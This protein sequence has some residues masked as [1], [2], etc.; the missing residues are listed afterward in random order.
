MQ[1]LDNGKNT[2]SFPENRPNRFLAFS[3]FLIGLGVFMI[4]A[5]GFYL[6]GSSIF[7]IT[8]DNVSEFLDKPLQLKAFNFITSS[9]P[10]IV[11]CIFIAII[12]RASF[13]KYYHF[14]S[15]N[16]VKWFVLSIAFVLVSMPLLSPLFQLNSLIDL[17]LIRPGLQDW[18]NNQEETNNQLY[19]SMSK[20]D[21]ILNLL[22]T[23][24]FMALMPAIAEEFFFRGF[25]QNIFRGVFKNVHIG[26]FVSAFIFAAIHMQLP[27]LLPM[28][29]IGVLFG[30]AVY[31]TNSIWTAIIAHF[32]NNLMA[33]IQLK[34]VTNG[35]YGEVL[36]NEQD[37]PIYVV[38]ICLAVA[39][40]LFYYIN[41]NA[42]PKTINVYE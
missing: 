39:S 18:F 6:I 36:K 8:T 42:S 9:L 31:W 12:I 15:P 35:D 25:L 30:Y 22:G 24:F 10:L 7:G 38:V 28:I 4:V 20:G 1:E 27:K 23:V 21:G 40:A 37:I 3:H 11:A 33:V 13:N 34:Y 32:L 16:N 26:I 5:L 2:P 14:R 41:K 17:D 29:F 19:E